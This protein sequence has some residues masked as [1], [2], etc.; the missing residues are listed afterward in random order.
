MVTYDAGGL[1]TLT[2]AEVGDHFLCVQSV[3][4]GT[5]MILSTEPD[6]DPDR[7]MSVIL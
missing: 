3:T 7:H 5:F 4:Q 1:L 6:I 2:R